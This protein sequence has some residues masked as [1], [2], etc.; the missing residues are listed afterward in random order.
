MSNSTMP[1][2]KRNTPGHFSVHFGDAHRV[3]K[4]FL[5]GEEVTQTCEECITGDPGWV[6]LYTVLN[7]LAAKVE[8]TGKVEVTLKN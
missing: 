2:L 8:K 6:R 7:T 1:E 5:D 4:V 3:Q